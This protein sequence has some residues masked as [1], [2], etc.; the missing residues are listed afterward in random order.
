MPKSSNQIDAGVLEQAGDYYLS[1]QDGT[2]DADELKAWQGW[3]AESDMHRQAF[4]RME[5][6]WGVLGEA[7]KA[8]W[9]PLLQDSGVVNEASAEQPATEAVGGSVLSL[10]APANKPAPAKTSRQSYAWYGAIAATFAAVM[11]T[12]F[13]ILGSAPD[14]AVVRQL[15][16]ETA[17]TQQRVIN[18]ADGSIVELGAGSAMSVNYSAETRAITLDRGEAVFTVA[19]NPKRPF[20]VR[21]G[22]GSVTAIGTV[23]NVRKSD[24]NVQVRVLE[25]TV[26]VRPQDEDRSNGRG[27]DSASTHPV[28]LVTAGS[29]TEYSPS[30]VLAPVELAD[31]YEGLAWRVGVLTMVD[32]PISDV[33][34]ELNRY[35][36]DE[37]TIGD[38]AVGSMRFT[39]T[40]YPDQ[41]DAWLEGLQEGYPIEV[42]RLGGS[43]IL[44]VADESS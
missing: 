15:Q 41:V 27:R 19:K 14:T 34:A 32:W 42:V 40:V 31:V 36:S 39:G 1:L 25:G 38:E 8:D 43:T 33:I 22:Q 29:Q 21:A 30:G 44:M 7:E 28:A 5:T 4:A 11:V 35:V 26:A 23:F 10:V 18:L 9:Q 12:T 3:M 13:L 37:I 2:M 24:L 6:L 17:A 20:V 16:Y